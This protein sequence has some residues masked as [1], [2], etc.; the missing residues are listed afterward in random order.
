M[1]LHFT[2]IPLSEN[3]A[4][5]CRGV[6]RLKSP[7]YRKY[8]KDIAGLLL[9]Q[10]KEYTPFPPKTSL[11]IQYKWYLTNDINTDYD[12]PIKPLQDI[13]VEYGVIDDDR[14]IR[15]AHVTK[16]K[17]DTNHFTVEIRQMVW[18]NFAGQLFLKEA[19]IF[20]Y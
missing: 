10:K 18:R 17:S 7:A 9:L 4:Y 19:D 12:N 8:E 6:K 13:L 5:I 14:Y 1:I 16:Y 15:E 20:P 2:G 3:K 11:Y